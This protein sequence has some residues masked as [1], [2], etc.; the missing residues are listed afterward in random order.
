[1]HQKDTGDLFAELKA[2]GDIQ[3]FLKRNRREFC[4]PLCEYLAE[5]L[6]AKHLEKAQVIREAMLE[7]TYGYHIFSGDKA[8]PACQKLI[9]LALVMEFNLAETQYLLRYAGQSILY[10]RNTWDSIIIYAINQ[11]FTVQKTNELLAEM[12]ETVL[13]G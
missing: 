13:L 7:R 5:L 6:H 11:N 9:S 4:R 3:A 8:N 12:G 10:P 1:M 2:D